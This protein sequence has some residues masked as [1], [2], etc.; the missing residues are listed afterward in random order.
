MNPL[1]HLMTPYIYLYH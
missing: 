1:S